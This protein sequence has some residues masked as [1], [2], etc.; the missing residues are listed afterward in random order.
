M[1]GSLGKR[2]IWPALRRLMSTLGRFLPHRSIER[3]RQQLM[4]AG[5]PG[6]LTALD[7][8]G[9]RVLVGLFMAGDCSSCWGRAA[10]CRRAFSWP[11]SL[12]S[13]A[14]SCR[15]SGWVAG[16]R[17]QRQILRALPNALDI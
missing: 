5:N 16:P 11:S 13:S 4:E 9:L 17:T 3:T 12:A 10:P 14:T 7:F 6:G 8:Y 15:L 2:V 1:R